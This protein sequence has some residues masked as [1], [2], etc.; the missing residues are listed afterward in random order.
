MFRLYRYT[1]STDPVTAYFNVNY[2]SSNVA[3]DLTQLITSDISLANTSIVYNFKSEKST[4]GSTPF[5]PIT[6]FKDYSMNDGYG[7]RV[8]NPST[9]NT[10]LNLSATVATTNPDISP[11]LDVSRY[12][13]I[14]VENIINSLPLSN[15]DITI[16]SGG[17][18]YS[19]NAN[20]VVTISGGGGSGATAAAVVTANVV[21]SVYLT[22]TGSGY[23]SSPT[24]TITDANTTPGS[25]ATIVYNGEDKKT[26]GNGSVRYI[27]RRVILADK[28]DSGD[29]RVYVTA[30]K[31]ALSDIFV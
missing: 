8:L 15:S 19:T 7:R 14:A 17:T 18:G 21:T 27:T 9:G 2:P 3:Y 13:I 29:L 1:F 26:G 31:P 28:F 22:A 23:T 5:L 20:A 24:I 25:G 4:G 6:P 12:G 10:T 30:Y 11:V 16:S